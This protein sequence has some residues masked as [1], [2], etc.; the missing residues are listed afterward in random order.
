[1]SLW[2]KT[3]DHESHLICAVAKKRKE[4]KGGGNAGG[5]RLISY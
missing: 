5:A 2:K 3:A 4:V 1:M